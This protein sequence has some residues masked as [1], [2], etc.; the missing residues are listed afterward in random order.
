[1]RDHAPASIV[2]LPTA[3]ISIEQVE[4]RSDILR[5]PEMRIAIRSGLSPGATGCERYMIGSSGIDSGMTGPTNDRRSAIESVAVTLPVSSGARADQV[6]GA[7]PGAGAESAAD[8]L[9]GFLQAVAKVPLLRA[10]EEVDLAKRVERGD[11]GAKQKMVESNLRLVVWIAK[12]YRNQGLPFPDLI[13]E[14]TLGLVRAVEKFDYRRGHKLSTYATWWIRQAIVRALADKART[15]RIPVHVVEKVHKIGRAKSRLVMELGHEPTPEEIAE[16]TDIDPEDVTFIQYAT[17]A[18]VSLDTPIGDGNESRL[19]HFIADDRSES[20][21]ELLAESVAR[22]VLSC[23]LR[24]LPQRER[25]VLELRYGLYDEAP[26]T[27]EEIGC[28]LGVTRERIRQLESRSLER[29]RTHDDARHV[30]AAL[31]ESP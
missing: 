1:M 17:Q 10:H 19:G 12:N 21:Y 7:S 26:R 15:I 24:N 13:Q 28:A 23:A 30:W 27:Y 16:V 20:P 31:D 2:T 14:G 4:R 18:P 3:A 25:Q 8:A 6:R 22:Q 11:L 29:L 5:P 9:H